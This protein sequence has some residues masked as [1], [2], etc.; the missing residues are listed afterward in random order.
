[1]TAINLHADQ[2]DAGNVCQ[3]VV[4]SYLTLDQVANIDHLGNTHYKSLRFLYYEYKETFG[5][6]NHARACACNR[7]HQI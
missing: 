6:Q 7:T 2:L 1:M 3:C 5:C 4:F